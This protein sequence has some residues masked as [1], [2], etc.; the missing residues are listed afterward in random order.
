MPSESDL[1]AK[2]NRTMAKTTIIFCRERT[3][4][5]WSGTIRLSWCTR[6]RTGLG[7]GC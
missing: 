6:S 3:S 2:A 1:L 7:I 5:C 4:T